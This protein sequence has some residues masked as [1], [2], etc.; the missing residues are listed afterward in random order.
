MIS[1]PTRGRIQPWRP[2]LGALG[3]IGALL[4]LALTPAA[5]ADYRPG[6]QHQILNGKRLALPLPKVRSMPQVRRSADGRVRVAATVRYRVANGRGK[7]GVARDRAMVTLSVAKRLAATGAVRSDPSFRRA[8]VHRFGRRAVARRYS[9]LLPHRVSRSLARRGAFDA[10]PRRRARALRLITLDVQIDRDFRQVDGRFDWR[11][12][13]AYSAADRLLRRLQARARRGGAQASSGYRNPSGTLTLVNNTSSG[14]YC[15]RGCPLVESST[16]LPGTLPGTIDDSKYRA[17]LAVTGSAV[18]CFDQGSN[19]SNPEGFANFN[20]AGEPQPYLAGESIPGDS[21]IANTTGTA[22]TQGLAADYTLA[23]A[24]EDE[25]ADTSGLVSGQ[26][27]LGIQTVKATLGGFVSPGAVITGIL[28]IFE[29]FLEN[30]CKEQGNYFNISASEPSGGTATETIDAA[31]ETWF[32]YP[33]TGSSPYGLQMNPSLIS[34]EG[35]N[36]HLVPMLAVGEGLAD[37]ACIGCEGNNVVELGWQNFN[38][39]PDG[40]NCKAK[41]PIS[42]VVE[43]PVGEIDC[44]KSNLEC[45]FPAAGWPGKP[46]G[47]PIY[48]GLSSGSLWLCSSVSVTNC[49]A[50]DDAGDNI[51][52]ALDLGG[53][54][55]WAGISN[56]VLWRCPPAEANDC[57]TLDN[58]GSHNGINTVLYSGGAIYAGISN[59]VLW[60]CSPDAVNACENL[61]NAEGAS[62]NALAAAGETIYA[63]RA[64]GILWKCAAATANSCLTLDNAG[65]NSIEALAYGEGRLFAGISNGVVWECAPDVGNACANLGTAPGGV[66][67]LTFAAGHVFVAFEQ[68]S[69]ETSRFWRCTPGQPGSCETWGGGFAYTL[70]SAGNSLYVGADENLVR[71]SATVARECTTLDETSSSKTTIASLAVPSSR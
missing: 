55:L 31:N 33:G 15:E 54:S 45:P 48:A 6:S 22:V 43:N 24:S 63:G 47:P 50:I 36:L 68:E 12:G 8:I 61:A 11:E 17:S 39:C 62:I 59:G 14:V 41:P 7:K 65:K 69:D 28:G 5:E 58:A 19:G 40:A 67:S 21:L 49:Q 38:P 44:G 26:V 9:V 71:C 16:D 13:T 66:T 27:K 10:D 20:A 42:P 25:V 18:Q 1:E 30:S 56:G 57:T 2:S 46:K 70:T 29:Y 3:L 64:D 4:L 52:A 53:G 37:N 34:Y 60:R 51:V 32:T 35:T 23:W